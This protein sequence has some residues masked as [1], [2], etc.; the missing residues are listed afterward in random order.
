MWAHR[1]ICFAQKTPTSEWLLYLSLPGVRAEGDE[2]GGRQEKGLTHLLGSEVMSPPG[3]RGWTRARNCN[4]WWLGLWPSG[5]A[6]CCGEEGKGL[7][8]TWLAE[9]ARIACTSSLWGGDTPPQPTPPGSVLGHRRPPVCPI[10]LESLPV[11]FFF[12]R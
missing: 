7:W 11:F 10:G 3:Y 4:H 1:C 6:A 8:E 9:I 12:P 5:Q 2:L